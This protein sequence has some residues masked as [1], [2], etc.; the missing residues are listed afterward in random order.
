MLSCLMA[1]KIGSV[2][3]SEPRISAIF[4]VYMATV[5]TFNS[6]NH[7]P[8]LVVGVTSKPNL[9]P[10]RIQ[11]CFLHQ[12]E[13]S[14]PNQAQR[15]DMLGS[16]SKQY[17]LGLLVDLPAIAQA[18]AGYVLGDLVNLLTQAFNLAVKDTYSHW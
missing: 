17:N 3:N 2:F 1:W 10:S 4:E 13:M 16:L 15:L 8:V 12:L 7:Y 14:A 9:V 18:T 5:N 11:S 6:A